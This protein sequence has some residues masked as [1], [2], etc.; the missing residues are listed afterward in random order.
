MFFTMEE[1]MLMKIYHG[2][3]K[4]RNTVIAEMKEALPFVDTKETR[5][6]MNNVIEKLAA[7]SDDMF[8]HIDFSDI[9]V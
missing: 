3:K 5:E 4:N 8:S 9:P 1:K 7:I 6:V 2:P